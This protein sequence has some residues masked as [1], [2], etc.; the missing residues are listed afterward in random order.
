[1][2]TASPI[3]KATKSQRSQEGAPSVSAEVGCADG[4][5]VGAFVGA[6]SVVDVVSV[7]S[8]DSVRVGSDVSVRVD[9]DAVG[10][11]AATGADDRGGSFSVSVGEVF[12]PRA[13]SE[14]SSLAGS[15]V[16]SFAGSEVDVVSPRSGVRVMSGTVAVGDG[17]EVGT[18]VD[19]VDG[20]SAEP[21][22]PQELSS[23]TATARPTARIISG[24]PSPSQK[25]DRIFRPWSDSSV[26]GDIRTG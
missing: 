3:T 25:E 19:A 1:M 11:G 13:G 12:S 4:E 16:F 15:E 2:A 18:R 7:G 17:R 21:V 24:A 26:S 20:R 8:D 5:V 22:S 10:D 9:S 14:V 6:V 23:S